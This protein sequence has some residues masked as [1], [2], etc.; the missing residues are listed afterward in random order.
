MK[1]PNT[2]KQLKQTF[3]PKHNSTKVNAVEP[4]LHRDPFGGTQGIGLFISMRFD[5]GGWGELGFPVQDS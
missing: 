5:R 2:N 4:M 3:I 1:K